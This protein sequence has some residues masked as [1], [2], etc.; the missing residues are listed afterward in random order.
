MTNGLAN[1]KLP[2]R[3]GGLDDQ[4]N[5]YA[6][7]REVATIEA[8]PA[9]TSRRLMVAFRASSFAKG[10]RGAGGLKPSG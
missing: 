5:A 8:P 10:E 9:S 6:P 7:E 4:A 3:R 2:E 1:L